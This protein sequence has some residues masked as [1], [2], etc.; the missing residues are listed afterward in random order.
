LEQ[1]A[2]L[3][4]EFSPNVFA[5]QAVTTSVIV[6]ELFF[7]PAIVALSESPRAELPKWFAASV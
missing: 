2:K 6:F 4:R 5:R 7:D 1:V 3:C